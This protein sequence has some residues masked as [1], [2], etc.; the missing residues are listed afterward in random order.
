MEIRNDHRKGGCGSIG[1]G[2]EKRQLLYSSSIGTRR[3]AGLHVQEG[4][5][6][7]A[8][9]EIPFERQYQIAKPAELLVASWFEQHGCTVEWTGFEHLPKAEQRQIKAA[10][11]DPAVKESR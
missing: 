1:L 9:R 2:T 3:G 11:A 8:Q 10:L 6:A 5:R 7:M 4:A